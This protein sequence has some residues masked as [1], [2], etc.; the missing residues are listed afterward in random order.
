M[1]DHY[2]CENRVEI[3]TGHQTLQRC[4]QKNAQG[5]Q[6]WILEK[7]LEEYHPVLWK[8]SLGSVVGHL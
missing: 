6:I 5:I 7:L 8:N 4:H 2:S 3:Q 1:I